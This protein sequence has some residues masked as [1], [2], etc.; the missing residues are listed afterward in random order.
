MY[1]STCAAPLA[2][3]LSYC[4]RCGA[5]LKEPGATRSASNT[6]SITAFVIAIT[7]IGL[8]GLG[9]ILGGTLALTQDAHLGEPII[10]FFM[11][12][13]FLLVA[14]TEIM[15]ARQ[16]S[17]LIN[18]NE[19]KA[20]APIAAGPQPVMQGEFRPAQLRTLPEPVQ[21]VTENTTRTLDY[22]RNEP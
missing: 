18:T 7:L 11:L 19:T 8:I 1:C 4:N 2:P 10:G 15:L 22:S 14:I 17:R 6:V 21:S 12:F 9:I 5:S 3:G 20:I 16:L 13:S